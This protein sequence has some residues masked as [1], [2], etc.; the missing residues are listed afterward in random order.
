M[1]IAFKVAFFSCLL[2]L[3]GLLLAG[4]QI[5]DEIWNQNMD[6]LAH[7]LTLNDDQK[8]DVSSILVNS[9]KNRDLIL[10]KYGISMESKSRVYLDTHDKLSLR[11][12]MKEFQRSVKRDLSE[13]LDRKQ[14]RKFLDYQESEQS[15]FKT[16]LKAKIN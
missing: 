1:K 8:D 6:K 15:E 9:I 3:S 7:A 11:K 16:R 5:D 10:T 4:Q 2:L 14:L 13:V 12:E